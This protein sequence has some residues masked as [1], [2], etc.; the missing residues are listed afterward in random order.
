M[1][2][3]D[4]FQDEGAK[5][6]R[7]FENSGTAST[8]DDASTTVFTFD[9]GTTSSS[10]TT[11]VVESIDESFDSLPVVTPNPGSLYDLAIMMHGNTMFQYL[12]N[13]KYADISSQD[14]YALGPSAS[15]LADLNSKP[16]RF[17]EDPMSIVSS[18][19]TPFGVQEQL[20]SIM[21]QSMFPA[22]QTVDI[23]EQLKQH[24]NWFKR[25]PPLSGQ[26]QLLDTAIRAVSLAHIGRLHG[27]EAFL[28]ESRPLYGKTLR[29]LSS[30]LAENESGMAEETLAATILL[31][32]YEMFSSSSNTSWIQHAGGAGALMR[33]RGPDAHRFGFEREMFIAYRH[34][35]IIEACQR[36]EPCFLAEPEWRE[37]SKSI[38]HD[39]RSS[40][41]DANALELF[42]LAEMLY[43]SMLEL[44]TV[45]HRSKHLRRLWRAEQTQYPTVRE[46]IVDL[47]QRCSKLRNDFKMYFF[48]FKGALSK[49]AM[50]WTASLSH[51]PTIPLYYQF[52]NI[53][54]AS[55]VTGFWTINILLNLVLMELSKNIEPEKLGL[56]RAENRD[57]ALEICR[58]VRYMLSSS[59]LGPFFIIFGLRISLTA[60]Q[61]K[62]ERDWVVA[63][64]FEIG[65]THMAMASRKCL[66]HCHRD[67]RSL[68]ESASVIVSRMPPKSTS[69]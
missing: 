21:H 20:F 67:D 17:I 14:P 65:D 48:K 24:G 52:P 2:T 51:D 7:K 13:H 16:P 42:D 18:I 35:I 47:I 15:L 61:D 66:I 53:F 58:S 25:L 8:G 28:Q 62:E 60:L 10:S 68:P 37:L 4:Q 3:D 29:L 31:S 44:P 19:Y 27:S 6:R 39:L 41:R 1:L 64:L 50:S 57:S 33:A 54:V 34:T 23:P 46:F 59:F 55:S 63:K 43:D 36:D 11:D 12:E 26:N 49:T 38:F 56:Y 30:S 45:L 69:F 40:G 5:L 22:N 32:F 9:S